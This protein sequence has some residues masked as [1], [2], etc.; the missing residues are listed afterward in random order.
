MVSFTAKMTLE[1]GA[2]LADNLCKQSGLGSGP[3]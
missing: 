2:S 1:T 3:T